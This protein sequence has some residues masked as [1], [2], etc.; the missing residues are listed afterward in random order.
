[1]A[2]HGVMTATKLV[3]KNGD[4]KWRCKCAAFRSGFRLVERASQQD[5]ISLS[6]DHNDLP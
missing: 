4:Q 2:L 3:L 5:R 6:T 1:M